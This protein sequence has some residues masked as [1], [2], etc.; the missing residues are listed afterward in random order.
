MPLQK[1]KKRLENFPPG[2]GKCYNTNMKAFI[3]TI[4]DEI[5]LGQILDTNSRYAARALARLGIET[6]GMA[7]I[8]D[9]AAAIRRAVDGAL[10]QADVVLVTGGLGPTKDDITKQT[11]AEYF[12]TQ[13]IFYP[14]VYKWIQEFLI[15]YP[16]AKNSEANKQQAMLPKDVTLLAN[17]K[18][19]AYGMWFEK[20]G[21]ILISLPGVPFEMEYLL[22]AEVLPRLEKR[23]GNHLLHY[24]MVT[25]LDVPESELALDLDEFERQLPTGMNVA[26]LPSPGFVR[27]RLTA[28]ENVSVDVLEQHWKKLLAL[29]NG[30]KLILQEAPAEEELVAR[31]AGLGVTV[32][33]AESCT[34]GNIA[35]LITA[36][37]GASNYFLGG[38]V[39]Y[40]NEVKRQVLGVCEA[41]LKKYGAVSETVARQMAQGA[42][43]ITGAQWAVS[44]TGIAGPDGGSVQKPV[45]T[46]WIGVA[47]PQGSCAQEFHFSTTRE[48]NI[49]RASVKALE[50]LVASIEAAA[51]NGKE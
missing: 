20:G 44:T 51:A 10:Q 28:K 30:K 33:T 26:Y 46:V 50:L 42:R 6:V 17:K 2:R 23:L 5:L 47:G 45:G 19:T 49:A 48:R 25:V 37:A 29:L 22:Q 24:K 9:Q 15:H 38:V 31:L 40:A 8:S 34:G 14:E 16:R 13:L 32:A 1:P 27:L 43:K 21:K 36:R 41:D 12:N 11:L 39:S 18:G 7:S 3:I 35:R 4:G